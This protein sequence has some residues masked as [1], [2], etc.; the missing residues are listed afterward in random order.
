MNAST[1]QTKIPILLSLLIENY[2]NTRGQAPLS[3]SAGRLAGDGSDR[4]YYR[5]QTHKH[6][7]QVIAVEA[8]DGRERYRQINSIKVTENHSF[9]FLARH[10]SRLGFPVPEVLFSSLDGCYYLLQDLGTT[11]LCDLVNEESWNTGLQGCYHQALDLLIELQQKAGVTFDPSWCYAGGHYDRRLIISRELEYFLTSFA[12]PLGNVGLAK[13]EQTS[14]A[15]EFKQL[16]D[17][18]LEAPSHY[19]LHRDY[20]SRNLMIKNGRIWLL[21]FQGARLGPLYYDLASL[22][23]DP[24]VAMPPQRKKQLLKYY[25]H[26]A[27]EPLSLPPR[28]RFDHFFALFSLIRC[29]QVLGA[30]GFLSTQKKRLH[31]RAY[32]PKA[33]ADAKQFAADPRIAADIPVLRQLISKLSFEP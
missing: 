13:T 3:F 8:V 28:R 29:L 17:R 5:I 18:A 15:M 32:I 7:E 21:D 27:A 20:Q 9:M 14:L 2:L 24:Y 30:F 19:F 12:I 10:L 33:L 22:I 23:N 1:S 4:R 25:Y 31:F 26:Q 16:A 11:T 6:Q